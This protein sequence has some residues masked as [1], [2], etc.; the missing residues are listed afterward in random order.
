MT[1]IELT[2]FR[3]KK[4]KE[5]K[6]Q[7]WMDFLNEHHADTV[8]TMAGEKMH[9]ESVFKEKIQM[10]I[11]IFTGIQFKVKAEMLLKN[12]KAILIRNILNIGTN[13][14]IW[15]ISQLI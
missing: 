3:I 13:V 14:L 12:Q 10:D 9:I 15:N 5:A 1:K 2:R 8:A 6:A 4:G 11:H 7:E